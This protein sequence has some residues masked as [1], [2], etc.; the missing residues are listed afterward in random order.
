MAWSAYIITSL[1]LIANK[2]TEITSDSQLAL[3]NRKVMLQLGLVSSPAPEFE[4]DSSNEN[5]TMK[6]PK[7]VKVRSRGS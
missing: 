3:P 7:N 1:R 2:Q 4:K 5:E 6:F